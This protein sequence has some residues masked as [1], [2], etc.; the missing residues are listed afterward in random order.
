MKL[1][2]LPDGVCALGGLLAYL[3]ETQRHGL[4]CLVNLNV[5]TE[6]QFMNLDLIARK[7]LELTA[8]MRTGEKKGTLLWVLDKTKT[9]MGKRLIRSYIEKPLINPTHINNRL[10]AVEELVGNTMLLDDITAAL[11]NIFDLER[12]MTRIVFGNITPRE[13]KSLQYTAS[14]LP[15]IKQ[16]MGG[17]KC[18]LLT[19][20]AQEL[21][22]LED[23]SALIES[24]ICDE[25]PALFRDGGFIKDGY[26][27]ELDRLKS[28]V[29]GSK[30][31]IAKIEAEEREK[32]GIKNLKISFNR[33]F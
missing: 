30:G 21:D 31:F 3:Y 12:L 10:N 33:V 19:E 25:P 2:K 27:E 13:L 14:Y 28:I 29:S 7:N 4:D 24:A 9:P 16:C 23:I 22:T 26:D 32:T 18:R 1:N 11:A 17:V 5:Y 8:T 20:I 15:T 6:K